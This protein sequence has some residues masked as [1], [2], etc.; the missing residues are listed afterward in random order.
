MAGRQRDDLDPADRRRAVRGCRRGRAEVQRWLQAR[1]GYTLLVV[2]S[3]A[4]SFYLLSG[5]AEVLPIGT[6]YAIWT[7]IGTAGTALF[8][9]LVLNEPANATRIASLALVI[10][11]S[12]GMKLF[13]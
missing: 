1:R 5:A 4:A 11:G 3:F 8:G 12:V 2:V 6:A 13:S 9:M 7:G 10:A